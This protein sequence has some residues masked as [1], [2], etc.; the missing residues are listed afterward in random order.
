MAF[1]CPGDGLN[2]PLHCFSVQMLLVSAKILPLK[3]FV[4]ALRNVLQ[5]TFRNLVV[6]AFTWKRHL[7][8]HRLL[9]KSSH[10]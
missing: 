3:S 2:P 7:P 4:R 1:L 10:P 6:E 9:P 5:E 8:L